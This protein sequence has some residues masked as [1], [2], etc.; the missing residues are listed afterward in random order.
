MTDVPLAFL[1]PAGEKPKSVKLAAAVQPP[2]TPFR[3][4]V[5]YGESNIT[6]HATLTDADLALAQ[7]D[8][9]LFAA[10]K[11]LYGGERY[12]KLPG[13]GRFCVKIDEY[14]GCLASP[15]GDHKTAQDFNTLFGPWRLEPVMLP[16]PIRVLG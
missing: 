10:T 3:V 14:Y 12:V 13:G 4:W 7:S 1:Q 8:F 5:F 16:L 6:N 11:K 15:H 2:N 9:P